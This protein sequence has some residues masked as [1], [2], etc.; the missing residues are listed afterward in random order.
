MNIFL[1]RL[2]AFSTILFTYFGL[3][4]IINTVILNNTRVID[5][6]FNVLINGD[7]H[8]EAAFNPK[9][10]NSAV[11]IAQG[12]ENLI[13]SY[14]KLKYI[15]NRVEFDTLILSFSYNNLSKVEE[16]K[17]SGNYMTPEVMRR[18]I[19]IS[20]FQ[21]IDTLVN[22]DYKEYYKSY[23]RQ[24]CLYPRKDQYAFIGGFSPSDY[25][26]LLPNAEN[27]IKKH[28]YKSKDDIGVSNI[29]LTYLDSIIY[30]CQK[31]NIKPILVSTPLHES[32]YNKIPRIIKEGFNKKKKSLID[33]NITFIDF[34][35]FFLNDS[36]YYDC[37]HLNRSGADNFTNLFKKKL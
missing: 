31:K 3:C 29:M 1:K 12:G 32:Y 35:D 7:S 25:S 16:G 13:L 20:D 9:L 27:R 18:A 36:L 15:T 28:Y 26:N 8:M 34:S 23:F 4:F 10:L 30:L 11:N 24:M 21:S 5:E 22:V 14:W 2:L 37:D 6:K 33:K 19:L 17:F